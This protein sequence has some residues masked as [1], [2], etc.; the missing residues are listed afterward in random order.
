MSEQEP[1]VSNETFRHRK[2]QRTPNGPIPEVYKNNNVV[3][4]K[5]ENE[6]E[7]LDSINIYD[8]YIPEKRVMG[9]NF[10]KM[11]SFNKIINDKEAKKSQH[12]FISLVSKV[13]NEFKLK[14]EYNDLNNDLLLEV[15]NCSEKVFIS[16]NKEEREQLK[17]ESIILLMK[18]F[19]RNDEKLIEYAMKNIDHM[20]KRVGMFERIYLRIKEHYN[21]K[22]KPTN[23]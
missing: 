16:K 15:V 8:S 17:K 23:S 2:T 1:E 3:E 18:P 14:E 12:I 22:K 5:D 9:H 7:S 4:K 19:F 10:G 21:K 11:K 13:I 6:N 20:I